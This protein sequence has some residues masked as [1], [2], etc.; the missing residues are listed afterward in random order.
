MNKQA[1]NKYVKTSYAIIFITIISMAGILLFSLTKIKAKLAEA[2]PEFAKP[3]PVYTLKLTA[4]D[5]YKTINALATVKSGATILVKSES[6]GSI[7]KLPFKEG[8]PVK[9]GQVIALIDSREQNAQLKAAEARKNTAQSQVEAAEANLL[10]LESQLESALSN[11][12]FLKKELDRNQ[13]LLKE[14][15]VSQTVYDNVKN[16]STEAQSRVS[17]LKAQIS[18][19]KAQT[20]AVNAQLK[21]ADSDVKIWEVRKNYT[22]ITAPVDGIISAKFQEENNKISVQAPIYNIEDTSVT[23]LITEIPQ[24]YAFEIKLGQPVL[25]YDENDYGFKISRIHPTLNPIRQI[26]LEAQINGKPQELIYDMQIPVKIIIQKVFATCIPHNAK[27][28]DFLDSNS[29]YVY[30][31]VDNKA[32]RTKV[33]PIIVNSQNQTGVDTKDLPPDTEVAL[34]AYLEN[35]RL[36]D[37]FDI[38]VVK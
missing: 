38:E 30:K 32:V 25:L 17:A 6:A 8:D 28:V 15:A 11:Q 16:K 37:S 33:T 3:T 12:E 21:A 26:T 10:A 27:F 14:G 7:V 31:I 5:I 34:G 20:E 22:E 35:L 29:F 24:E 9:A 36:P 13:S 18:A 1:K 19:Q 23:R 4:K 2:K